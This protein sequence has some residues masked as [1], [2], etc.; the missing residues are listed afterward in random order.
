MVPYLVLT[1]S[2]KSRAQQLFPWIHAPTGKK[3]N[4]IEL[5]RQLEQTTSNLVYLGMDGGHT[6][7]RG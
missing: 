2:F 4:Q 5:E 6:G 1:D 7:N 3:P